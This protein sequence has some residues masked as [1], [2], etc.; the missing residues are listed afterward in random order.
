MKIFLSSTCYNLRDLRAEIEKFLVD[1][2]NILLLS[3]RNNFPINPGIHRHDVCI[4]NVAACDLFILVID[5][6]YGAEYYKDRNVSIT[7]AELREAIR[8]NRET[9]AFVRREVFDERQ[10]CRHNQKKGNHF[11]PFYVDNIKIFDIIDEI[12]KNE[13]GIWLQQFDNSI[14]VKIKLN[15]IY[16]TKQ[17]PL[18]AT[19]PN[20]E[21]SAK[22]IPLAQFSGPTASFLSSTLNIETSENLNAELLKSAITKIPDAKELVAKQSEAESHF[23]QSNDYCY[24]LPSDNVEIKSS[25][26]ATALGRSIRNELS[27][28]LKRID[29]EVEASKIFIDSVKRKPILCKF[30]EFDKKEFIL[31]FYEKTTGY[32]GKIQ[33][34]SVLYRFADTWQQYLD[35]CLDEYECLS[36]ISNSLKIIIHEKN[37]YFYFERLIHY[38]GTAYNGQGTI[39]FTVFDIENKSISKLVYEGT[40]RADALEGQFDFTQ[41]EK[42]P[43]SYIYKFILE[44]EASKS[45]NIYRH[46]KDY[47]LDSPKNNIEKWNIENPDFYNFNRGRVNFFLYDENIFWDF[48]NYVNIESYKSNTSNVEN[49]RFLITYYFAGPILAFDKTD[50]KYFVI[51]VPEGYGAGGSWGIRSINKVIFVNE[52]K[53]YAKNDYEEYEIDLSTCE[54][55]RHP[56][57]VEEEMVKRRLKT[58]GLR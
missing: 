14:D 53:I 51:L 25:V 5:S 17:S 27:E 39:E 37:A 41:L 28:A 56:I 10:T 42:S 44:E 9:I 48:E 58:E 31:G 22:D 7:W 34:L 45:K 1:S 40:Y 52:Q 4:E 46:P 38:I 18:N 8:T 12:Q 21:V 23:L 57:P 54:Y 36:E 47:N 33:H 3:D 32:L 30:F 6:R 13:I 19:Q 49:E 55:V 50:K 29:N 24:Y 15:S 11:D 16:A 26:A 43:K 2:G 35:V 20:L